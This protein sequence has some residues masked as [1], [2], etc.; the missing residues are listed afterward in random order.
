MREELIPISNVNARKTEETLTSSLPTEALENEEAS[1]SWALKLLIEELRKSNEELRKERDKWQELALRLQN[2]VEELERLA[3][4]SPKDQKP[5]WAR[6]IF[7][8]L[9]G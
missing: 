3:L 7:R 4:P 1:N 2:R 5:W 9:W 6:G 8:W